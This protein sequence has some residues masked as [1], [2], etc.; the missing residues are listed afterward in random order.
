[1]INITALSRLHDQASTFSISVFIS[2]TTL[3][4]EIEKFSCTTLNARTYSRQAESD[5][6]YA[7]YKLNSE[8]TQCTMQEQAESD[9]DYGSK[10]PSVGTIIG[11]I[12]IGCIIGTISHF[13]V[14]QVY[15]LIITYWRNLRIAT[16][17]RNLRAS[18]SARSTSR[19]SS[20]RASS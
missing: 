18:S 3:I 13:H 6:D 12:M 16:N 10:S 1:M 2:F 15:N 14:G 8:H 5:H 20:A 19:A 7:R 4:I 9:H 11:T 17:M